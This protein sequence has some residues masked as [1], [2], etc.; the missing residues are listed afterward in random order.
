MPLIKHVPLHVFSLINPWI[1]TNKLDD[2]GVLAIQNDKAWGMSTRNNMARHSFNHTHSHVIKPYTINCKPTCGL[3]T[4]V[5]Q[6]TIKSTPPSTEDFKIHL[7]NI[8]VLDHCWSIQIP[9]LNL[10]S[11]DGLLPWGQFTEYLTKTKHKKHFE[12][13]TQA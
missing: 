3:Y 4:T 11:S 7:Q 6:F 5:K 10:C 1:R 13:W 8:H 9:L 12:L 2:R